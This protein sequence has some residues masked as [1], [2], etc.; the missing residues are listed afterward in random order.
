LKHL[1]FV[2]WKMGTALAFEAAKRLGHEVTLIRSRKMEQ[3]QNIDFDATPYVVFVD[4]VYCLDDATD[5]DV[6]R[7]CIRKINDNHRIDGFIATVD[8][9]VLPVARIA[10]ELGIPFTTSHGALTAKLKHKCREK[11]AIAGVEATR[12]RIVT[13]LT[14]AIAF[15]KETGYPVVLKPVCGSA[16]EGAHVLAGEASLCSL[17]PQL[18]VGCGTYQ[19]GILIEEYLSGKFVS[20]EIGISHGR[21]LPFAVSERKTWHKHEAL[22]L[23]A[24]IPANITRAEYDAVMEFAARVIHA[25]DL[26]LGVFHIEIM[27]GANGPRLIELNPRLM[28]SCMPNLFYLAGGGDLFEMLVR[29]YL[30]EEIDRTNIAFKKFATVRWFGAAET[31]NKPQIPDLSWSAEYGEALASLNFV[32]PRTEKLLPC[33]GNLGN[34]GEVQVAHEDYATSIGIAEEI[35]AKIESQL[36]IELTR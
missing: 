6:L 24:T 14:Q 15:A 34:F 20:A 36:G 9:L 31:E 8:A 19:A 2:T 28:G 11:L 10:E 16:S 35:V 12:Y 1:V 7:S 5:I 4:T 27:L 21:I 29:I 18:Q 17:F 30:N 32:Y 33:R 13:E 22:E 26:R 23:G 3:S 25:V